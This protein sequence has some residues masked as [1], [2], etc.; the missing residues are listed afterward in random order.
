MWIFDLNDR[1]HCLSF[2]HVLCYWLRHRRAKFFSADHELSDK[3]SRKIISKITTSVALYEIGDWRALPFEGVSSF[4][5][6]F[7]CT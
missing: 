7:N 1:L 4:S 6:I 5:T 3:E 2:S